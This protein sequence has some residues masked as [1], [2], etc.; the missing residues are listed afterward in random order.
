MMGSLISQGQN[1]SNYLE[2]I[3][4]IYVHIL[5]VKIRKMENLNIIMFKV[6]N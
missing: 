5:L 6:L 2:M 1:N 3:Y 4:R